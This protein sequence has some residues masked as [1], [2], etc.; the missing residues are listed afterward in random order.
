MVDLLSRS[1][2][3]MV[4]GSNL[5]RDT[6]VYMKLELENKVAIVTG[7][8]TGIGRGVARIL[9]D[10]GAQLA[11]VGR[12][13]A[14]LTEFA[15]EVEGAGLLR[16]LVIAQDLSAPR[17]GILAADKTLE[18]FG[19]VDILV[20]NA[21]RSQPVSTEAPD[22]HWESAF[23]LRFTASRHLIEQVLPK[24]KERRYGRIINIGGTFEPADTINSTNAMNAARA[25]YAKSL[26]REVG[27]YGITVNTLGP[28]F[29]RSEQIERDFTE[30]EREAMAQRNIPLGYVGEPED[31]GWLVALLASPRGRYITGE[32]FAVDGG[33]RRYG[34]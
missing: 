14:L 34:F 13:E 12:R 19:H 4:P 7:A 5:H 17:G 6:R 15:E 29:I 24:M 26:S 18:A 9:A 10:E 28:G 23:A 33:M 21:G 30:A 27:R 31:L 3:V 25:S 11:V 32:V 22:E 8:G 1:A 16:P 2:T 20:N